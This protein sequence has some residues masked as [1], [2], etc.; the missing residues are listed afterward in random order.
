MTIESRSQFRQLADILRDAI[1]RGDYPAGSALPSEND[2]A[3]RYGVSRATA[4]RAVLILRSEGLVSAERGR[5]VIVRAIPVIRRNAAGRYE[6]AARESGG[7]RGAFDAEIRA[8]GMAPRTD[9]Q[10]GPAVPPAA[11]AETLG[12]DPGQPSTIARDRRMYADD[13]PVQLAVSYIPADIAAGT[14]LAEPDS[15]PGGIISRFAELGHAQTR[16]TET[17]RVRRP[18]DAEA[19]FLRLEPDQPVTEIFHVGWT[20]DDRA[21]EVCVHTFPAFV[22]ALDYAWPIG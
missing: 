4:N 12:V 2:L 19:D 11:V 7:A 17:V 3:S 5:G 14:Q 9:V 1:E 10:V 13:I 22:W 8:L 18:T 20:A 21:V 16:V 15:G 6:R